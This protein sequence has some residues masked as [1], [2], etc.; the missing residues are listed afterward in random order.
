MS[1]I[2]QPQH[3]PQ[4]FSFP[5]PPPEPISLSM[6]LINCNQLVCLSLWHPPHC[7]R[8]INRDLSFVT[9]VNEF[10]VWHDDKV[11]FHCRH[12][13][14]YFISKESS[15][16]LMTLSPISSTSH[17]LGFLPFTLSFDRFISNW[18]HDWP[19]PLIPLAHHVASSERAAV[20]NLR[21]IPTC[22]RGLCRC[23]L[24]HWP[25]PCKFLLTMTLSTNTTE[26]SSLWIL[27]HQATYLSQPPIS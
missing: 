14:P 26:L 11:F 25:R 7:C 5:I 10:W 18:Q 21:P 8:V 1:P 20:S 19:Q 2:F 4:P 15:P 17:P 12:H 9:Q 6:P 27:S 3:Y 16:L 22:R 24:A 23:S 13:R